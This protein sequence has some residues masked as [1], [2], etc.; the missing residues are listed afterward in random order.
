VGATTTFPILALVCETPLDELH[1][2]LWDA[3]RTG[4]VLRIEGSYAFQHDRIQEAAYL[5]IPEEA[6][7]GAHLRIGRLLLAHTPPPEREAII[8]EI[9]SQFSQSPITSREEREQV[10]QLNL[11]A[12]KRASKAA[13]YSSALTYFAGGCA[14]L[15]EDCWARQYQLAFEL[16]FHRGECEFLTGELVDAETRLAV[17]AGRA[18]NSVDLVAVICL[19]LDFYLALGRF[20]QAIDVGIEFLRQ[21]GLKCGRNPT[22]EEVRQEY[23]RIWQQLGTRRT[24]DLI[25]LPPLS[26]ADRRATLNVVTKLIPPAT[27]LNPKLHH[28]LIAH[29]VN[30]S[31]EYGNSDAS[32]FGYASLGWILAADFGDYPAAL[33]FGQLGVDLLENFEVCA[34]KAAVYVAFA[35]FI[36]PWVRHL[37]ISR[38]FLGQASDEANRIGDLPYIGYCSFLTLENAIAA[39]EPLD[40]IESK[41]VENIGYARSI[42]YNFIISMG[43]GQ[44]YLVRTLRGL[45]LDFISMGDKTFDQDDFENLLGSDPNLTLAACWYWIRKLQAQVFMEDYV[46]AVEAAAKAQTLIWTCPAFFQEADYHFYAALARAGSCYSPGGAQPDQRTA[47]LEG[48][49]SH[50]R[51]LKTWAKHCP[52]NFENRVALV[53]AEMARLEGRDL[54]AELLYQQAIHSAHTNG[55]VHNE[56]LAW[57][58]AAR[59]Y[60]VR[61]FD[62]IAETYFAKACEAYR[63]WG[64]DGKVRLLKTRF[65]RLA[66]ADPRGGTEG[67]SPSDQQPDVSAVVKA[68]QALSSEIQLPQLIERLMTIALQNSGADR[69]LLILFHEND[70]RI[71]AEAC[72]DGEKVLLQYDAPTSPTVP[73]TI[74]RYVIR[75]QQN[76]I[77]DDAMKRNL[78]SEDMYLGL[79]KPRSILCLPLVRQGAIDGLLYLENTLAPHVFTPE[80]TRLLELLASQAAI[81]LENSRL[82]ADLELQVSLLQQLPVSA[83]TLKPNGTPDFVNDVWLE[84]S[85]QTLEFIRSHPEAWMTAIHPED[86]ELAV[87]TFWE[88]VRSGQ[89]FAFETRTLRARDGIY[90]RHLQQAVVLRDA[91]GKVLRFVGTT[92]DIDDQKRAEETLRQTQADFAHVARVATLN[93]MTASIAHEVNQPL[94]GVLINANTGLR[95]LEAEPP[96]LAGLA[97]TVRR[98]VRDANRAADVIRRLREMFSKKEAKTEL[99]DLNGAVRDVIAI[100]AGDLQ[101]REALLQTELAAGLP[102]VIGDHVQ[103]QQVILNLLLNAADAMQN[104]EDRP[105]SILVKTELESDAF[106]QLEVRDVG[107]G[108]DPGLAEKLFAPFYTTK[109]NG[110]GIGLSI[111]RSIIESHQGRIWARPN[112]GPGVTFIFRLPVASSE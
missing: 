65:P 25:D 35:V 3:V 10:A 90:R 40:D 85:G 9:V 60:A 107:T 78:F 70:Y 8:F 41:I 37:R 19:R 59:F 81:S 14:L 46:S 54:D 32:C 47:H 74:I 95:M 39:G 52:E 50:H 43:V 51:Q 17:L 1:G 96:N 18:E 94:S 24:E 84:F 23:A 55:F 61:G 93:A 12:G 22:E 86:R 31:L 83:W 2:V 69:G 68:S 67:V 82:Y 79:R 110:M 108:F 103:L 105:R 73:E 6:R 102:Y 64:A 71:E 98:T 89:G 42:K 29:V 38:K 16:E 109:A 15:G 58:T 76:V 56:A 21:V 111:C 34:S 104:I 30:I 49:A 4:L 48:L 99:V 27:V 57:E 97:E 63:R 77:L 66:S 87:R 62:V 92:T 75:T 20:D 106:V 72:A 80:R 28:L 101:R 44:L 91:E 33:R 13:A 11:I 36:C 100:S 5:L 112:V 88:G 45:P 26:D 53:G 7:A